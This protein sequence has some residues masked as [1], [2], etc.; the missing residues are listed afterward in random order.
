MRLPSPRRSSRPP[1]SQ[2]GRRRVWTSAPSP[3][4]AT[5][6]PGPD[7]RDTPAQRSMRTTGYAYPYEWSNAPGVVLRLVPRCASTGR[8]RLTSSL[9]RRRRS[10]T[11]RSRLSRSSR[12]EVVTSVS[13][14][15]LFSRPCR[16]QR[17]AEPAPSRSPG[18][19]TKPRAEL[20]AAPPRGRSSDEVARGLPHPGPNQASR[21]RRGEG[22]PPAGATPPTRT[23]RDVTP[24]CRPS[25]RA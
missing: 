17:G 8:A 11:P 9:Q 19:R 10:A 21:S 25:G 24:G 15:L 1:P 3:W 14:G 4:Q 7:N 18:P 2:G 6:A 13:G 5:V 23:V 12:T 22:T 20:G 16:S